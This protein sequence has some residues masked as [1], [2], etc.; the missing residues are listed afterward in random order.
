MCESDGAIDER[1]DGNPIAFDSGAQAI[2]RF[3]VTR[4]IRTED[5]GGVPPFPPILGQIPFSLEF[6]SP[7]STAASINLLDS[8]AR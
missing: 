8:N 1:G 7:I 3:G 2:D 4:I 5:A 6:L